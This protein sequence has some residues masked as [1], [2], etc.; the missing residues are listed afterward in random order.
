[1]QSP[2]MWN[3]TQTQGGPYYVEVGKNIKIDYYTKE[4]VNVSTG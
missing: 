2:K 1:M 4:N 3:W